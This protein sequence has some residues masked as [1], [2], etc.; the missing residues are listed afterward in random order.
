MDCLKER[1]SGIERVISPARLSA[2]HTTDVIEA[3]EDAPP[4]R[5]PALPEH[6]S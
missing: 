5:L 3:T 6:S 1:L 2:V 4:L